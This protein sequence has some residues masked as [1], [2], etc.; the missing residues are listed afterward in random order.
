MNIK[1]ETRPVGEYLDVSLEID[2][3]TIDGGLID[4]EEAASLRDQL[5]DVVTELIEYIDEQD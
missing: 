3:L 5:I 4:K 2:S 1:I